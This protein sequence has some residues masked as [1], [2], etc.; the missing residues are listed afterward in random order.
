MRKRF[1]VT[2]LMAVIMVFAGQFLAPVSHVY[3]A[4]KVVN[5]SGWGG[6][7][8]KLFM[9]AI[10]PDLK[11]LTGAKIVYTPGKASETLAK[12]QAQ[13]KR[14]QIDVAI[15]TEVVGLQGSNFG[16]W[17]PLDPAIVT[18]IK[19]MYDYAIYPEN[20]GLLWSANMFGMVYNPEALKEEGIPAP[21]SWF[22]LF[23]KEYQGKIIMGTIT[24]DYGLDV[25]IMMAK[26]HGGNEKNIEPG[27]EA[28]KKLAPNIVSFEKIYARVG[29][30]F[31]ARTAW[32][33]P[34]SHASAFRMKKRGIPIDFVAPKEGTIISG[35]F[36]GLVENAPHPKEAQVFINLLLESKVLEVFAEKYA[37]VPLNKTVKLK[38]EVAKYV[39]NKPEDLE[40]VVQVDWTYVNAH[41]A[42]WTERWFKEIESIAAK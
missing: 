14:P 38:P 1:G 31:Q 34:W 36:V 13:K 24:T 37:T 17:A 3:A 27:F 33:A 8:Q 7:L 2:I 4:D 19:N 15:A 40:K 28:M 35:N 10:G 42:E 32:I 16:L 6:A 22:D 20:K 9:D 26:I 21:T 5:V 12:V 41:R 30:L 39:P 11:R 23:K 25:L 18:N 29:E